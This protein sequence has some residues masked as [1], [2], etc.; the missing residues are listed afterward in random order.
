[1]LF[2]SSR[3]VLSLFFFLSQD[4]YI[5]VHDAVIE[6]IIC[7]DNHIHVNT[8]HATVSSLEESDEN[9]GQTGYQ[10]QF[11]VRCLKALVMYFLFV[12][13]VSIVFSNDPHTDIR[14][15]HCWS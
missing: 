1:M 15:S 14:T 4:Q 5:L 2:S 10:K 11:D 9:T 6:K 7:G 3:F 12:D 13:T 8:L